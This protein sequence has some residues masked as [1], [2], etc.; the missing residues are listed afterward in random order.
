MLRP[1]FMAR[2]KPQNKFC[3]EEWFFIENIYRGKQRVIC[4]ASQKLLAY[5]EKLL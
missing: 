5:P 2:M 1:F 3:Y 4:G